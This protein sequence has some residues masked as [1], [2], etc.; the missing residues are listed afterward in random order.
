[1]KM[2]NIDIKQEI[3]GNEKIISRENYGENLK[4]F[5]KYKENSDVIKKRDEEEAEFLL[6]DDISE[7]EY[8]ALCVK[9]QLTDDEIKE[10][11]KYSI[12]NEIGIVLLLTSLSVK[13]AR[14]LSK[15]KH[16]VGLLD[17]ESITDEAAEEL[18]KQGE[19]LQL[20]KL[21][22]ITDSQAKSFAK[23]KSLELR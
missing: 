13:Q 8:E 17:L 22:S 18:S 19:S 12:N 21:G 23:V 9:N 1:M 11:V 2:K 7:E 15:A 5:N 6:V 16:F 3:T 14:I 4:N 20:P 10:V